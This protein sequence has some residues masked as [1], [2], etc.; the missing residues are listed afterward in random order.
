MNRFLSIAGLACS[1]GILLAGCGGGGSDS[2]SVPQNPVPSISS[3]SP[4]SVP[5]GSRDITLTVEG[6]NFISSSVVQWGG[7]GKTTTYIG[8]TKLTAA[9]P[10]ADLSSAGSAAVRVSNPSPGGG[11][12]NTVTL[13]LEA[14]SP[15][16]VLTK[17]LP[18]AAP[19]KAYEYALRAEGGIQPYSWSVISG[20]LPEGLTLSSAGLITGTAP[21]VPSDTTVRF[22]VQAGDYAYQPDTLEQAYGIR[23]RAEKLG[24]NDTCETATP[25]SNGVM[26]AS[27]SPYGDIDVYSFQGTAGASVTIEI[28]SERLA[29]YSNSTSQDIFVDSFLELLD[30]D[31]SRLTYNDDISL[32]IIQDSLIS[33]YSLP[34]TGTYFIRVSDLRGDGRPDFIY[35]LHLSGVD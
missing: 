10:A 2:S 4:S 22:V 14:V 12:S 25:V 31:C 6:Q 33:S 28:Y 15:L 26:R 27:L 21:S 35:D 32:G 19:G 24:R 13:T 17:R 3:I 5:A 34:Y 7:T 29:L 23:V 11:T 30:S 9:I 8:S 20:S 16:S 18:D 1:L